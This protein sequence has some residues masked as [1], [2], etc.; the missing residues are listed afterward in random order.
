MEPTKNVD[1]DEVLSIWELAKKG[2]FDKKSIDMIASDYKTKPDVYLLYVTKRALDTPPSGSYNPHE[3]IKN[4]YALVKALE[5]S[6]HEHT[7]SKR[8]RNIASFESRMF[9][10]IP[11]RKSD[12]K[13]LILDDEN[14]AELVPS[15]VLAHYEIVK[16]DYYRTQAEYFRT[17][18]GYSFIEFDSVETC[19]VCGVAYYTQNELYWSTICIRCLRKYVKDKNDEN[20]VA[21]EESDCEIVARPSKKAKRPQKDKELASENSK[22]TIIVPEGSNPSS[23]LA[24][25]RLTI[26]VRNALEASKGKE[27]KCVTPITNSEG[28][29]GSGTFPCRGHGG[30][31]IFYED[32]K[33][34]IMLCDS[35]SIAAIQKSLTGKIDVHFA[36]Y[37]E[38]FDSIPT[39]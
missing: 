3:T 26:D 35:I 34:Y 24:R 17:H 2:P 21:N 19:I 31:V 28:C 8:Q 18:G 15:D 6:K 38:E 22:W 4:V 13:T 9:L 16:E 12:P 1:I 11:H 25:E 33:D 37:D 32:G 10:F 36:D 20:L 29:L 39:V 7:R 5:E 30:V 27:V 14:A 23:S